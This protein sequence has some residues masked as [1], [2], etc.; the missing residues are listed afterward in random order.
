MADV[1]P[2][3]THS[4][5]PASVNVEVKLAGRWARIT[6]RDTDEDRLLTRLEALLQ[7][8]PI[9]AE[10]TQP[11]AEGW[12]AK[13]SVQMTQNHKNG[14]SWWSHKTDQGWCRGR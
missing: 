3:Q 13:H 11:P 7:R 9:E 8:F 1:K 2:P 12:C 5:A 10:A 4:E 6:L 14:S